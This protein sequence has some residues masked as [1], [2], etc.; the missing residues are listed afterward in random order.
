MARKKFLNLQEDDE[1]HQVDGIDQHASD[2]EEQVNHKKNHNNKR[3]GTTRTNMELE[4]LGNEF[5]DDEALHQN[6]T[7]GGGVNGNLVMDDDDE[8]VNAPY[9]KSNTLTSPSEGALA[10]NNNLASP[11]EENHQAHAVAATPL[12]MKQLAI[13]FFIYLVDSLSLTAIFAY[14]GFMVAD[15]HIVDDPQKLGYFAGLIASSYYLSQ[16]F[17]SFFWGYLSDVVGRRPILLIGV[18][19]GSLSCCLFGFSKWLW[20]AILSRFLF[21]LLN[22]NLG[23][24]KSYLT[25]ITDGTNRGK[26]FSIVGVTFG[27]AAVL[28]PLIGGV[29][30]RP[31]VQ[32]PE[33]MKLFPEWVQYWCDVFPY[34]IPNVMVTILGLISVVLGYFYL[35]ET[36]KESKYYKKYVLKQNT[37]P[38]KDL[39]ASSSVQQSKSLAAAVDTDD[40]AAIQPKRKIEWRA[41][42]KHEIF[43]GISPLVGCFLYMLVGFAQVMFDEV[44]PLYAMLPVSDNGLNFTPYEIGIVGAITGGFIFLNQ[45]VFVPFLMSKLGSINAFRVGLLIHTVSLVIFPEVCWFG[46]D[47][48]NPQ[49]WKSVILWTSLSIILLVRQIGVGLMFSCSF[50]FTSNSV[51]NKSQGVLNGVAQSMISIA[52]MVGP[53]LIGVS[54]AAI[55][56]S[57]IGFPIDHRLVFY[58]IGGT[59]VF[60]FALTFAMKKKL[61]VPKDE[62]LQ[63]MNEK[64]LPLEEA[65]Q[66][67]FKRKGAVQHAAM[68]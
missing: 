16:L 60:S 51:T 15:F 37:T 41:L 7:S 48:E 64:G 5:M 19:L 35:E 12:P 44:F 33:F 67:L 38:A 8:D 28:G 54:F 20:W 43:E 50:V 18:T 22:G 42:F 3:N 4:E 6:S 61:N 1:Q 29:F 2:E 53:L 13:V 63:L 27:L 31:N 47:P 30:S 46:N 10:S 21:G 65:Y 68:E 34:I 23:V 9:Y 17:S 55:V 45:L 40:E 58:F 59:S 66:T 62:L 24:T 11:E 56:S 52:R 25:E 39:E 57:G 14:I 36:N 32:Y 49:T 26:A